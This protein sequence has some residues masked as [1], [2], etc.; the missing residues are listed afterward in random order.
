MQAAYLYIV[1]TYI[2]SHAGYEEQAYR[3][4]G[5]YGWKPVIAAFFPRS[6]PFSQQN[7][8]YEN[9]ESATEAFTGSNAAA[10][11]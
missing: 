4:V 11:G 8:S 6:Y 7:K 10:V 9:S 2:I 5:V 3:F 1:P